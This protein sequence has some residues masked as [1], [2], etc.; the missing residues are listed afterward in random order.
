MKCLV[1]LSHLMS[2]DCELGIESIARSRLAIKRFVKDE[3]EFLITIGWAYRA[4]CDTPISNVVKDFI[5]ENS[6]ID[7]H[8]IISISSSRDTVGDAYYC[9]EYL[10]KFSLR[11]IHIVTSDY[12]VNRVDLIFKKIFNNRFAVKVFG[13]QTDAINE[14]PI[15]L[16]EAQSV[17]VFKK[18]FALTD[19]SNINSIYRTLSTKHPFYNGEIFPKILQNK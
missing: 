2:K 17:D 6:D 9:L 1:V 14:D 5:L 19:C 10:Q 3:Y 13:T 15:L 4:D 12:H 7:R 18:T 11:E 16:L 8:S